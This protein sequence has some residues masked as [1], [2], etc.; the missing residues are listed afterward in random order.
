M[1]C[2]QHPVGRDE[3]SS[4]YKGEVSTD[5]F[6]E[7]DLTAESCGSVAPDDRMRYRHPQDKQPHKKKEQAAKALLA[8]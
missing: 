5:N 7:L 1:R 3:A 4:A 2:S 6:K 8:A